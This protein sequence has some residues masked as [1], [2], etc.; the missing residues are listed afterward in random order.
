LKIFRSIKEFELARKDLKDLS[1][2]PTMGNLHKGHISLIDL[3]KNYKNKIIST[4]YINPLQFN[5]KNDFQKYPKTLDRDIELLSESGCDYLLIPDDSILDGIKQIKAP[6]KLA[7]K[8]CG[9]NR[10]GHFDGVLTILNRLFK[11]V[12]PQIV[13]FGKKDYQQLIIVKDF[14]ESNNLPIIVKSSEI[15][16]DEDGLALSSRNNLLT[17]N[18]RAAATDIYKALKKYE[19]FRQCINPDDFKSHINFLE[20][21]KGKFS[22]N[23][24]YLVSCDKESLDISYDI[25][26]K[27]LLIAIAVTTVGGV[28]LIDNIEVKKL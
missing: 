26:K 22:L 3:A 1:Y 6:L 10:P 24:D 9:L 8:L 27:D 2:V 23:V 25:D 17:S 16:R 14:I 28:R 7:N 13:V 11:I 5:D 20:D 15:I 21:V 19:T 4:I 18:D 12:R